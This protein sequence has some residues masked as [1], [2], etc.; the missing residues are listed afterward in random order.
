MAHLVNDISSKRQQI[1]GAYHFSKQFEQREY[2]KEA[3]HEVF[4]AFSH[5]LYVKKYAGYYWTYRENYPSERQ[6]DID[7]DITHALK[8]PI[9][10]YT[11]GYNYIE[12]IY[13]MI[14]RLES[15]V[16]LLENYDWE[17][18]TYYHCQIS[19]VL[20]RICNAKGA[21]ERAIAYYRLELERLRNGGTC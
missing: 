3:S 6:I 13:F 17:N 10:K 11:S 21:L 1:Y 5:M 8:E 2:I 7:D 4:I 12:K 15:L 16:S 9:T 14:K 20:C 18:K 19:D